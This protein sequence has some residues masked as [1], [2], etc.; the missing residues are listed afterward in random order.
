M[1]CQLHL[2]LRVLDCLWET[3]TSNVTFFYIKKHFYPNKIAVS[4]SNI[5]NYLILSY[6]FMPKTYLIF[7]GM[8]LDSPP[9]EL[10]GLIYTKNTI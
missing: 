1:G 2:E 3:R 6:F 4:K 9:P 8:G 5:F 7:F 10:K